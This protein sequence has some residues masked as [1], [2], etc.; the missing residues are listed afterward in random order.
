MGTC[1]TAAYLGLKSVGA[2][3]AE[4]MPQRTES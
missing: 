3:A 1:N 2:V 4:L